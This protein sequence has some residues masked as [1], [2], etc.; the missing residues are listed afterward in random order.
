M[1][2]FRQHLLDSLQILLRQRVLW[3]ELQSS[4]EV[5]LRFPQFAH[6]R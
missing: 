5:R 4:L 2:F 1:R 3:L 6:L